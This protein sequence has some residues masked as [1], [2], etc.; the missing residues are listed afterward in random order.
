MG[1][2][3][4][5]PWA[6][7]GVFLVPAC[8]SCIVKP[9]IFC[10]CNIESQAFEVYSFSAFRFDF[11]TLLLYCVCTLNCKS[12]GHCANKWGTVS[13]SAL[14]SGQREDRVDR[15]DRGVVQNG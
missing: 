11:Y 13:Y 2:M 10:I 5:S 1:A 7:S 8:G 15:V 4:S 9:C 14:Q 3:L 6:V 12:I